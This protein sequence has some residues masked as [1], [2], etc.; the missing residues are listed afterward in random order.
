MKTEAR[1]LLEVSLSDNVA[2]EDKHPAYDMFHSIIEE[3]C[4]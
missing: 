4:G 3:M 1:A 2:Y